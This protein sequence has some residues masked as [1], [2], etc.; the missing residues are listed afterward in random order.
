MQP[1]SIPASGSAFQGPLYSGG[2]SIDS[3]TST[4][5]NDIAGKQNVTSLGGS[6]NTPLISWQVYVAPVDLKAS[7]SFDLKEKDQEVF[8]VLIALLTPYFQKAYSPNLNSY[9]AEVHYSPGDSSASDDPTIVVTDMKVSVTLQCSAESIQDYG[10]PTVKEASDYLTSFFSGT[11]LDNLMGN[12]RRNGVDVNEIVFAYANFRSPAFNGNTVAAATGSSTEQTKPTPTSST[13]KGKKKSG[14]WAGII[15][16]LVVLFAVGYASLHHRNHQGQ[17]VEFLSR[18]GRSYSNSSVSSDSGSRRSSDLVNS[19]HTTGNNTEVHRNRSWSGSFRRHPPSGIRPAALQ[20]K[21]ALSKD[22]LK[23]TFPGPSSLSGL[24]SPSTSDPRSVSRASSVVDPPSTTAL[25][26]EE[27]SEKSEEQV[28][29]LDPWSNKPPWH[30]DPSFSVASDYNIPTEY[31]IRASPIPDVYNVSKVKQKAKQVQDEEEFSMPE[32]Y[33]VSPSV[34]EDMSMRTPPKKKASFFGKKKQSKQGK[35]PVV[36]QMFQR[37]TTKNRKKAP[38]TPPSPDADYTMSPTPDIYSYGS[39]YSPIPHAY[40]DVFVSSPPPHLSEESSSLRS[41]S[42]AKMMASSPPMHE[43]PM[44]DEWSIDSFSTVSLERPP[45]SSDGGTSSE[46]DG[47]RGQR[48]SKGNSRRAWKQHP[49]SPPQLNMP[50][51]A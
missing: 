46:N 20:K 3:K 43:G 40:D 44:V 10:H 11:E 51:F 36:T 17:L 29:S 18:F 37:Q 4:G 23:P 6:I 39:T 32:N 41:P 28:E 22:F 7:S 1:F 9:N 27:R 35:A 21:P 12:L 31:N 8:D 42:R 47:G 14:M 25:G 48:R 38:E 15:A 2:T 24:D 34:I 30:D 49:D 33:S 16:G 13:S 5:Q 50:H 26:A 19:T 45:Q